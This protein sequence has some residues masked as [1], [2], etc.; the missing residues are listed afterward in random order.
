MHEL[1]TAGGMN[2]YSTYEFDAVKDAAEKVA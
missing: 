1:P 2:T